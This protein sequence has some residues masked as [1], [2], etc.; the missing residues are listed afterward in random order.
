MTWNW[1]GVWE[2]LKEIGIALGLDLLVIGFRDA[3]KD[4]AKKKAFDYVTIEPP[5]ERFARILWLEMDP[6]K[7]QKLRDRLATA[8]RMNKENT[9]VTLLCKL[10]GGLGNKATDDQWR[11]TLV[12]INDLPR[13]DFKDM[14]YAVEHDRIQQALRRIGSIAVNTAEDVVDKFAEWANEAASEVEGFADRCKSG[15]AGKPIK[16]PFPISLFHW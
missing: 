14:L 13:K 16:L 1:R 8:S 15:G 6:K 11:E 2:V 12:K 3:A 10:L 9:M 5:R 4:H 7:T